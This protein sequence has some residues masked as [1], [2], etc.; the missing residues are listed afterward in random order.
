MEKRKY[1]FLIVG[2]GAGGGTLARELARRGRDVLVVERGIPEEKVGTF[3]NCLRY[4]DTK[5]L[6]VPATS[7]EGTVLWRAMTAGGSTVVSCGNGVRCLEKE[8]S[9]LG[10]TLDNEFAEAEK[11][12]R[13]APINEKLLSLGSIA[14]RAAAKELGYTMELMPKFIYYGKCRKCGQCVLGCRYEGK[15]TALT[16]L[17]EA[18]KSGAQVSYGIKINKVLSENGRAKGVSGRGREGEITISA[19]TV[20]LS[21]GGIGT[22]AILQNSGI[23]KAGAGFFI[24]LLVNTYGVTGGLNLVQEPTMAL[25]NH[26]FY[27]NKGF[28]LSPFVN[29]PGAVRFIEAGLRG[30]M[31]PDKRLIGIM[32]KIIDEPAGR[33]Y[34]DGS[35]SKPVTKRDRHRLNEGSSIS[36]EILIKAGADPKSIFISKPQGAHPGGT[37]AIGT[38]VDKDLQTEINNLF[39]CDASVLPAAP[40]LPPILTIVALAKR[41]AKKL[42]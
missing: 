32:T 19:D 31:A 5:K 24:D 12:M 27:Q 41:L 21:A 11:E 4:Y 26:D 2:S 38:V 23:S 34:P 40:G 39:V 30:F 1:Q 28:I 6:P 13:I 3:R 9:Q 18:R 15:W 14:L 17:E 35:V 16:Y 33:V 42:A 8:L 20:I 10:I 36:R 25:V 37:A 7:R 22:P 29:H